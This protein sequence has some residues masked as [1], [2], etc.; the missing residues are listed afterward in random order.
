MC[1]S[2][3][4]YFIV[5]L[6]IRHFLYPLYIYLPYISLYIIIYFLII[7]SFT[8]GYMDYLDQKSKE[9]LS[10]NITITDVIEKKMHRC[11]QTFH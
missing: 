6:S 10:S 8:F 5:F 4:Q 7:K 1:T 3:N 9:K 2:S 11:V